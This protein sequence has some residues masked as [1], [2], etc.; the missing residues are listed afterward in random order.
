MGVGRG[1]LSGADVIRMSGE[2]DDFGLGGD[3][4][5]LDGGVVGAGEDMGRGKRRELGDVDG[6]LVCIKGTEDGAGV[7]VEHLDE[8]GVVGCDEELTVIAEMC[9]ACNVLES[10]YGLYDLLCAWRV[11]LDAGR[12]GDGVPVWSCGS[13]MYGGDGR[14]LLDEHGTLKLAPVAGLGA[15]SRSGMS[16]QHDRLVV[17][18]RGGRG[19]RGSGETPKARLELI[20]NT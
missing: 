16:L 5:K 4:P 14:V 2:G 11:D 17:H 10:G 15:A 1:D 9:A 3:V 8:A 20:D 13:K 18:R 12:C 7:D 19:P 6:L